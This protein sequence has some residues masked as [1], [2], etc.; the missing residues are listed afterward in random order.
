MPS[1]DFASV[2]EHECSWADIA[3]TP[4]VVGGRTLKGTDWEGIKWS[5]KV[6]V[7]AS[8]GVSGGRV[9]KRTAGSEDVEASGSQTRAGWA[10]LME[11]LE[12]AAESAGLVRDDEVFISGIAF[13]ILIQHTPLGSSRIYETKLVGCRFLGDSSDM[14]QGNEA[15]VIEITLNPIKVLTKSSTGQWITLR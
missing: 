10:E 1:Q 11:A 5:R 6:E 12:E 13:D 14:K 2:N 4:M 15:E 3:I 8:R 9:R 7:G